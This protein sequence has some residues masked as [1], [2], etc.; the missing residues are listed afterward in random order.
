MLGALSGSGPATTMLGPAVAVEATMPPP[1]IPAPMPQASQ[2]L[3]PQNAFARAPSSSASSP[4]EPALGSQPLP[5]TKH[6]YASGG[7]MTAGDL[8]YPRYT[9]PPEAAGDLNVTPNR[10]PLII[11]I[12]VLAIGVALV[13][14]AKL[15]GGGGG[16]SSTDQPSAVPPT[17]SDE[18]TGSAHAA[19]PASSEA[20][21]A[22]S[23][24]SVPD[25]MI[26]VHVQSQPVGADVL[27]AGTKIGTTPLDTKLHRGT[28]VTQLTVH[29]AGYVD[30]ITKID[31]AGDFSK[32]VELKTQAE[33][34]A[35]AAPKGSA[36][37]G[38]PDEP[39]KSEDA[40]KT[41]KAVE[42]HVPAATPAVEHKQPPKTPE[43]KQ[44]APKCQQPGPNM[45]PFSG[46]PVCR[47]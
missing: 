4:A 33:V 18:P 14:I 8:G 19:G 6:G 17:G 34:D 9:A 47:S 32:D 40:H 25:E 28:A 15:A 36:A 30:V 37:P 26:G 31:L 3:I 2:P 45:D 42:H 35:A 10:K 21:P 23:P 5:S 44:P 13:L 22:P 46:I 1:Q 11:G 43:H 39:A 7:G 20:I 41:V 12:A 38:R 29:L 24:P 16:G 27:V